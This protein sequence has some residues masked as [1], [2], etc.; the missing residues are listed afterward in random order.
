MTIP[1]FNKRGSLE[2]GIHRCTS[3]EFIKRFCYGENTLRAK[4]KG[5]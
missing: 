2:K 4:Y 5:K 3:E 1:E